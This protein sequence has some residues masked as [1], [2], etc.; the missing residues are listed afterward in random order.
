MKRILLIMPYG[1]VGGMERLALSF[2][3]HYKALGYQVKGLKF[4]KLD[5]DI[6]NFGDDELF[7]KPYDFHAM[8]RMERFMF[9]IKA[10]FL[11][12][13]IVKKHN[14]TH[15]I[16]FGDMANLFSSLSFS[17]EYKI[18]SIHALK[19][20]EFANKSFL[21]TIFKLSYKTTYAN[22]NKVVCISKD[23]KADLIYG[24]GFKFVKK[25]EIIY[26]PHDLR[27]IEEKSLEPI[28]TEEE[29]ELLN[30][31]SILFVGRLSIQ[32]APW[33]LINAF[34]LLQQQQNNVNLVFIG[35]GDSTVINYITAQIKKL[36]LKERVFFLGRKSNP[37]KYIKAAN[38]LAL[39]SHY[40]GTPNVIVEA[41]AVGTPIVSSYCTK[42][43]VE[44]M[45]LEDHDEADTNIVLESGIVTPNL[46]K[47]VLGIP[48]N[49][50]FIKEEHHLA[51]ALWQVLKN[52]DF[53]ESLKTVQAQLLAKFDMGTIAKKYLEP[54][55]NKKSR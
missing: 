12:Y 40:E 22:L 32:K 8:S 29:L 55:I 6:I 52:D 48:Q 54:I 31:K 34:Y 37:Y 2:Y 14:I 25:L 17:K 13:K 1:S 21:N 50:D 30:K 36:G 45:G 28:E 10:P 16:T 38:V 4:I 9:Y 33:H 15:S 42:G 49:D 5:N 41:M 24:C 20:V 23:I 43:V 3:N 44:L 7:F 51:D 39:S 11:I 35:D 46:F 19:S 26:N 47:G 53:K 27:L 18:G